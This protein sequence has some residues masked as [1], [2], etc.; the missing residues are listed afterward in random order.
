[1]FAFDFGMLAFDF[2]MFAFD[3][4]GFRDVQ[5]MARQSDAQNHPRAHSCLGLHHA[6]TTQH[7]RSHHHHHHHHPPAS[8]HPHAQ[9]DHFRVGAEAEEEERSLSEIRAMMKRMEAPSA[10]HQSQTVIASQNVDRG[11]TFHGMQTE[12]G[13]TFHGMESAFQGME[14]ED[15]GA[16]HGLLAQKSVTFEG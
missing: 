13:S 2:G 10:Q 15:G 16:V 8:H 6:A 1:M 7:P 11:A 12:D 14:K 3:F 9:E 4:V 5:D